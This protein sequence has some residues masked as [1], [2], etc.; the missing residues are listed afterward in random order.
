MI[1]KVSIDSL[2]QITNRPLL[3]DSIIL[4]LTTSKI[5]SDSVNPVWMG[6][7]VATYN[8]KGRINKIQIS[9]YGGFFYDQSS[10][11]YYEVD[12]GLKD[13]WAQYINSVL[14]NT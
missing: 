4:Y 2:N 12:A 9:A 13:E 8:Y 6:G 14:A 3:R 1:F 10:A 5:L 7:W 11:R